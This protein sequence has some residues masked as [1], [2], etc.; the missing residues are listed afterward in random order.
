M[1]SRKRMEGKS[2][3]WPGYLGI[4]EM[5]NKNKKGSGNLSLY[6]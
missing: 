6:I 2:E 5:D 4:P 3:P 1:V